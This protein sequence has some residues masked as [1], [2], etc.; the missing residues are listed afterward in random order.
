MRFL[1]MVAGL[2]AML[3]GF[4][5]FAGAVRA[6]DQ[7]WVQI[8]AQPSLQ[9]AVER[10]RAWQ[11]AFPQVAGFEL[12]SGWHAIVLGPFPAA[13]AA[14]RL[15]TLKRENLIPPDSFI[16]DGGTFRQGFW[17]APGGGD[18]PAA[19]PEPEPAPEA[20]AE[21]EPA[22]EPGP[23]PGPE[24]QVQPEAEPV[25]VA[26]PDESP[27]EARRSEAA[28][29]REER[30][31]LQRALQW[32][33]FYASGIDGAIGPGTRKS[34]AAWQDAN[35]LEPTGILTTR[36]RETLVANWRADEAEFGFETLTEPEAGI[37]INLPLN[38]VAFDHYEPPFVHFAEKDGS[39]LRVI[40]I[41]QPGD[42]ATLA[43]LYDTLQTLE[44]VPLEGERSR[45]ADRFVIEARGPLVES[46]AE[47]QVSQ[48]LVKG[49]MLIWAPGDD[50]IARIL[51]AMQASFRPVGARALDPGLVPMS[52]PARA[53]LLSGLEI[54]KP[55]FSRSG[56]FIDGAGTVLT[57]LAAVQGCGRI[58]LD[59]SQE[60][61]VALADPASGLAV[62]TPNVPLSPMA[63][64][65]LALAPRAG[66]EVALS[67]YSY[68][69]ALPAPVLTFGTLAETTG[70]DGAPGL[71]RLALRA[72]P[73]DAGGPVLDAAGGVLGL[74]LPRAEGGDRLLPEGVEFALSAD[75]IAQV[76]AAAGRPVPPAAAEGAALAPADLSARA[77]G[78]TALVSCWE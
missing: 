14:A 38:L 75:R 10:A 39:G 29:P 46:H 49:F 41:S 25:E 28:L 67:G 4:A 34:M 9:Q 56:F 5:G 1:M 54:R 31:D 57:G 18:D 36:Q 63:V 27:A 44:V 7:A 19:A 22:S 15:V 30:E 21:P 33:G 55:L 53:G 11:A 13:E 45:A 16:T 23:E 74:L 59:R 70:L 40:L 71:N 72:L 8:E 24:P 3:A 6:Q 68:G 73:G 52:E 42:E 35:G 20:A 65:E 26:E 51:P 69:D 48:G 17:P 76:L 47:A 60:A 77:L 37:E 58:T 62:L 78:M 43:A 66:A 64:A 32:Y 61:T 2:L 12:N 50:R